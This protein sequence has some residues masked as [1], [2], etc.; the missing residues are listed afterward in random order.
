MMMMKKTDDRAG[1]P[2]SVE[3]RPVDS[4]PVE[5]ERIYVGDLMGSSSSRPTSR[6]AAIWPAPSWC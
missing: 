2:P 6:P 5:H 3:K 4:I 1:E